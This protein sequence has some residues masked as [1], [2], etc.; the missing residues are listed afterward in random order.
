MTVIMVVKLEIVQRGERWHVLATR[1]NGEQFRCG[2][3]EK[4]RGAEMMLKRR[5]KQFKL[6]VSGNTAS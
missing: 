5:A 2:D 6:T 4:E 1:S 3:V